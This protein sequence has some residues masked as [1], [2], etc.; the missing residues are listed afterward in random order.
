VGALGAG[1]VTALV[2]AF[3]V[4]AGV[5]VPPPLQAT[6]D[7]ANAV[8]ATSHTILFFKDMFSPPLSHCLRPS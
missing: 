2:V 1:V 6:N 4:G 8:A 7:A 5:G 3:G